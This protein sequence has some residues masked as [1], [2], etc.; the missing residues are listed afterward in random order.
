ML[1][2]LSDTTAH[3]TLYWPSHCCLQDG[4]YDLSAPPPFGLSDIREA[5]PKQCWEKNAWRSMGHLAV[6][7]AIVVGLAAG[8]Y[9]LNA[10]WAWPAYWLAQG[11][12]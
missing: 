10:W 1:I 12:M 4:S 6:D 7:V 9:A 11:T 3:L 2:P 8:A 5:I